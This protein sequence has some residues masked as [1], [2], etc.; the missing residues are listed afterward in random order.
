MLYMILSVMATK[1]NLP[2]EPENGTELCRVKDG[3]GLLRGF[4]KEI[5]T[6]KLTEREKG[7][8]VCPRCKGI[9]RE[10]CF[11]NKG[12]HLCLSCKMKGEKTNSNLQVRNTVSDLKSLC[13]I[14]ERGCKWEG[15]LGECEKHLEEC[16]HVYEMCKIGCSL[17]FSRDELKVHSKEMCSHRLVV[18]E[19]CNADFKYCD[20][21][22]HHNRCHRMPVRCELG[23]DKLVIREN[24][25][26]HMD[27]ECGEKEVNCPFLR[28][29]CKVGLIRR[30]EMNQ[31][32]EDNKF[33][34]M[35]MKVNSSEETVVKQ[36]ETIMQLVRNN[37]HMV[38][39]VN[40]LEERNVKQNRILRQLSE[41]I[42]IFLDPEGYKMALWNVEG[43]TDILESKKDH[44]F[45]S[46]EYTLCGFPMIFTLS[47]SKHDYYITLS[48]DLVSR[49]RLIKVSNPLNGRF[50][51]RLICHSDQRSTLEFNS[52]SHL[53]G[54]PDS[55]LQEMRYFTK[56][57]IA[58]IKRNDIQAKFIR[59]GGIQLQITFDT[60]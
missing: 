33:E 1:C 36:N 56:E 14:H 26:Q 13:P 59:D 27:T 41:K 7:L 15:N 8:L 23:C 29:G 38:M 9:L 50:I 40:S 48:F 22:T 42:D 16:G 49:Q 18:C 21:P 30:K 54:L 32:L 57:D 6:E 52:A 37:E 53:I 43:I 44:T 4:R 46:M 51:T 25:T 19:H 55:I 11:S 47:V 24:M 20:L 28:Y 34:H 45:T 60:S 35:V 31:H 12:E 2:I 39:K 5:L 17:V 3:E 10:A 58:T